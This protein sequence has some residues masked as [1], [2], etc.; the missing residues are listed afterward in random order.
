MSLY[1]MC[2]FLR[3]NGFTHVKTYKT[4]EVWEKKGFQ[5]TVPVIRDRVPDLVVRKL[6]L[7]I[8]AV[9]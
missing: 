6:K 5:L 1:D 9:R 4:Y 7:Q 2:K 8:K 3:E